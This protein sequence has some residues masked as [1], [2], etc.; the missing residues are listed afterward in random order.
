MAAEVGM[1]ALDY[2]LEAMVA[3]EVGFSPPP[4]DTLVPLYFDIVHSNHCVSVVQTSCC[5]HL[6]L[7]E[8]AV[9]VLNSCLLQSNVHADPHKLVNCFRHQRWTYSMKRSWFAFESVLRLKHW[10][11]NLILLQLIF[12]FTLEVEIIT[13]CWC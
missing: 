11:D 9:E 6:G 5:P 8:A 10:N 3:S 1:T 13:L 12:L 7:L 4:S 2:L